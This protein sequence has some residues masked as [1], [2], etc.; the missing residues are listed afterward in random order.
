MSAAAVNP[1][2]END[3]PIAPWWLVLLSGI[4]AIIIGGLLLF[5]PTIRTT[6]VLVQIMGWFWFFGGILNIVMIFVDRRGWVW[7]LLMGILGIIAGLWVVNN[8]ILGTV[9]TLIAIVWVLA[10]Q[11]IIYGIIALMAS[12]QGAGFGAAVMG[13]LSIVLGIMLFSTQFLSAAVLPWVYGSFMLV[14]GIIA[15]FASFRQRGMQKA[16]AG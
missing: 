3:N 11:A 4:S 9:T 12:F 10:I 8:P 2:A 13:I 6:V 5:G 7:N 1:Y 15:I 16:V 14:G